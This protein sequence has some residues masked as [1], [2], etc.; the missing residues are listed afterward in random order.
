MVQRFDWSVSKSP[1]RAQ[2]TGVESNGD[3]AVASGRR[4]VLL[5]RVG[6][7]DWRPVFRKG[8]T[9]NGHGI[10]DVA[11]TDDGKRAWYCGNSGSFGYYDRE[12]ETVNSHRGPADLTNTF[13]SITCTG[14]SGE[15][16][17]SAVDGGGQALTVAMDGDR[18]SVKG[19]GEPGD[20][21]A[22]T[23]II[24]DGRRMYASDVSGYVYYSR[25]GQNWRRKRLA[26]TT[27]KALALAGRDLAAITDG[28]TV[29]RDISLFEQRQRTEK[30]HFGTTSPEEIAAAGEVFLIAGC[31]GCIVPITTDDEAN[32]ADPG[33]GVTNYGAE[34]MDDGTV[35][36]VGSSGT[37]T[38]GTPR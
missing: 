19:V 28:G 29:Y 4:G 27:V 17:V 9:G 15:E 10:L 30:A 7:S 11:V 12:A 5:E 31:D 25:N 34:I 36:A 32:H 1:K 3:A 26:N 16:T 33:P 35:I 14:A 18:L 6:R 20:G 23:E 22:F 13:R 38:E 8:P 2:L 21:T 37:I 24:D